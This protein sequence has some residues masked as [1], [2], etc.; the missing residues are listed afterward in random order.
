LA[1]LLEGRSRGK[2]TA[3][4]LVMAAVL[5]F[6]GGLLCSVLLR[7]RAHTVKA[8]EKGGPISP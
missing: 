8:E 5:L 1:D 7:R 2:A 4:I 6:S 3:L